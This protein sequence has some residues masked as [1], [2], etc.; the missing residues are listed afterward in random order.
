MAIRVL[1]VDDQMLARLG[2]KAILE[3]E[4]DIEVVG[5]AENGREALEK[6][7]AL[8]PDV[9][10]VDVMMP[11]GDGI[12]ATR[13]I[14]DRCPRTQVLILTVHADPELFRKAALAGATGYVLKDIPLPNLVDAIRVIHNGKTMIYPAVARDMMGHSLN[15][16]GTPR[17]AELGQQ[18]GLT[19]RDF[20]VLLAV[21]QGLSDK[22]IASK[23]RLS[24]S[25]VKTHLRRIFHKLKIRN[26]TEAAAIVAQECLP[27][28]DM[29]E[30]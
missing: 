21:A 16:N 18:Y 15:G 2:L 28:A 7:V 26:R 27:S 12:E 1:I 4:R 9:A 29:M 10:L 8:K 3:S 30:S 20:D 22:E 13:A 11:G 25:T 6:A 19:K 14:K 5:E 17:F 23:L 24:K